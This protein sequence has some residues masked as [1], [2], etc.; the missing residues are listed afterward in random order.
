PGAEEAVVAGKRFGLGAGH[1]TADQVAAVAD[2][3]RR[4]PLSE[5]RSVVEQFSRLQVSR[6][7]Q[8][9][10]VQRVG[11]KGRLRDGLSQVRIGQVLRLEVIAEPGVAPRRLNAT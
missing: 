8:R 3:L 5:L 11:G 10:L 1:P 7:R 6:F 9:L 4:P 2:L